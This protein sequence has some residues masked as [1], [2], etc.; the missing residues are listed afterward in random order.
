MSIAIFRE[1][2]GA[3]EIIGLACSQ[4]LS[5]NE[6]P[7][8]PP[9]FRFDNV[10]VSI[11]YNHANPTIE[12]KCESIENQLLPLKLA[13]CDSNTVE[14]FAYTS[15]NDSFNFSDHSKLLD[16]IRNRF[17]PICNSS[18]RYEFQIWFRS[19][20]N[21]ATNVIASILEMGEIKHCSNVEFRIIGKVQKR[22]PVEEISN[23]LETS[24]DGA[25]NN[26]QN[27][28]ERFLEIYCQDLRHYTK[29]KTFGKCL[30][31]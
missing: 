4:K 9:F 25:K 29:F 19:N 5:P 1:R 2:D 18:R 13:L 3:A 7:T 31:N 30:N 26:H 24:A 28:K 20:A 23:W 15:Q 11:W 14:L 16:F 17:L 8:I 22:L 21:S 12:E 6:L 27:Q 10:N